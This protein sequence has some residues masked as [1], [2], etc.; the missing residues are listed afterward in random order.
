M[1]I[2]FLPSPS[3]STSAGEKFEETQEDG[4]RRILLVAGLV[5]HPMEKEKNRMNLGSPSSI[6]KVPPPPPPQPRLSTQ[7]R[8]RA[9]TQAGQT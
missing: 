6:S 8:A 9:Q 1:R 2:P 5:S 7:A 3:T 4:L